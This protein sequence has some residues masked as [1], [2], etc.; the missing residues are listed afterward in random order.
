MI[1]NVLNVIFKLFATLA[2]FLS[3]TRKNKKVIIAYFF[4]TSIFVKTITGENS[5]MRDLT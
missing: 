5:H 2:F 1:F 4:K 3:L